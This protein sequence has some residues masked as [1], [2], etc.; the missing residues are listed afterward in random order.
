LQCDADGNFVIAPK[1][2]AVFTVDGTVGVT[3][4]FNSTALATWVSGSLTLT[5]ATTA[6]LIPVSEQVGRRQ[7]IL[8]NGSDTNMF[9]GSSA[10]TVATGI[11]LAT[12]ATMAIDAGANLYAICASAGKV[13]NYLEGK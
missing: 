8:Y 7:L 10:V 4:T 2:G 12:G 9:I 3:G 11:L 1:S 13:L 5:S 6:Y